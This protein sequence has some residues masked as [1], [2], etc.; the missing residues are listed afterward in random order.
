MA[1]TEMVHEL[2]KSRELRRKLEAGGVVFPVVRKLRDKTYQHSVHPFLLFALADDIP[3]REHGGGF[4][5][6]ACR[7]V[8][9]AH[10]CEAMRHRCDSQ[11]TATGGM[12]VGGLELQ[13]AL[14]PRCNGCGTRLRPAGDLEEKREG[15][16]LVHGADDPLTRPALADLRLGNRRL[17]L[18]E[19]RHAAYGP[20]DLDLAGR[21]DLDLS[22]EA[23]LQ[24]TC[25]VAIEHLPE[26]FLE[27]A[28]AEAVG[29]H[30]VAAGL[31]GHDLHLMQA[32]LVEGASV[33]VDG[34]PVGHGASG[35][36]GIEFGGRFRISG[37]RFVLL[38]IQMRADRLRELLTHDHAGACVT[39]AA[40][41]YGHPR[42]ALWVRGF[43]KAQCD[44]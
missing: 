11:T 23:E 5:V 6:K 4:L 44:A 38:E 27:D 35:E 30:H 18:A 15:C 2:G 40:D 14:L 34:K 24:V 16:L 26:G 17:L 22:I 36:V 21:E 31:I 19:R 41:H 1:P 37:I 12:Q 33:D 20:R 13:I 39:R 3:R 43:G 25:F 28:H 42:A 9:H 32:H 7:D 8:R 29:H 10:V